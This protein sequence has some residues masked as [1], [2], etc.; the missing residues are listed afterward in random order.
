MPGSGLARIEG[1]IKNPGCSEEGGGRHLKML[2]KSA[3][4]RILCEG[5]IMFFVLFGRGSTS[6]CL[7]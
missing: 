3:I 4:L 2:H 7:S 6:F 1:V 5:F